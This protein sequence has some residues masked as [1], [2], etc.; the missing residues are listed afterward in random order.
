MQTRSVL[1][2]GIVGSTAYGLSRQ[3]SDIDRLAVYAEPTTKFH[4]LYMPVDKLA[5]K[6]SSDDPDN[7]D[8][9]LH[10]ARKYALLSLQCNPT[11]MELMWLPPHLYERKTRL[12]KKLIAIRHSFLSSKR[13]KDA[14]LGYAQQQ[15]TRLENRTREGKANFSSDTA[16]RTAKHARHLYRLCW[17]GYELYSGRG[18]RVRVDDPQRF[19]NFGESVAAGDISLAKDM[20]N[21]YE[22]KFKDIKS[23]LPDSPDTQTVEKWL[24]SVRRSMLVKQY[25]GLGKVFS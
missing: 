1:L 13:V 12:G 3:G 14:Y 5:T 17:Q 24:L 9:V 2:S 4:G 25:T 20:L 18:L 19:I 15:F 22:Q 7:P 11:V 21:E 23:P 6:K 10:E 8:Y 16:K